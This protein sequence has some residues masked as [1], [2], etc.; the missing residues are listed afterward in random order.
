MRVFAF[1]LSCTCK[2]S[3]AGAQ[4]GVGPPFSSMQHSCSA[5]GVFPS[6]QGSEFSGSILPKRPNLDTNQPPCHADK[7]DP[8]EISRFISA[9]QVGLVTR[10]PS[11]R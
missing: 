4:V 2:M 9:A 5:F 7:R 6:Q 3:M 10:R 8:T 11:Y 1:A